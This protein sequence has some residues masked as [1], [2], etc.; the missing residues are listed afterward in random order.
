MISGADESLGRLCRTMKETDEIEIRMFK[1]LID[2]IKS[3][4]NPKCKHPK[5][6]AR[7]ETLVELHIA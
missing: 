1:V 5:E 4:H 6:N 2:F 3:E 7:Y